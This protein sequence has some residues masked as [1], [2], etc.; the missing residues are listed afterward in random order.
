MLWGYGN[1]ASCCR[2]D[3]VLDEMRIAILALVHVDALCHI[4]DLVTSPV[5]T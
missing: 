1:G 2:R 3:V 5:V 4:M